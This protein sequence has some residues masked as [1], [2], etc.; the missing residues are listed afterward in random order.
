M[1]RVG[2]AP[3]S[4]LTDDVAVGVVQIETSV[5]HGGGSRQEHFARP[6]ALVLQGNPCHKAPQL[7]QAFK[8]P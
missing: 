5:D 2:Q 7:L 8:D 3:R 6:G 1:L 4:D